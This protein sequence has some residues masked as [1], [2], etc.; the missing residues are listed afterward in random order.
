MWSQKFQI[1]NYC[2]PQ[3]KALHNNSKLS[4]I[5]SEEFGGLEPILNL[6]IRS[7]K[8]LVQNL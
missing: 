5:S 6:T 3:I 7:K 2:V 1:G 4:K 8:I